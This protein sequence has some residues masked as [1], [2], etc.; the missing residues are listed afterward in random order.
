[1]KKIAVLLT[2]LSLTAVK[3]TSAQNYNWAI[4]VRAVTYTHMTL[5]TNR[6]VE[7]QGGDVSRTKIHRTQEEQ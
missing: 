6:E 7:I 2:I 3:G 1:M 4:G 5:P